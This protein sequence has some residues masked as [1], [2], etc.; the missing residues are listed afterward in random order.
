MNEIQ[1]IFSNALFRVMA[2]WFGFYIQDKVAAS[3][4][5]PLAEVDEKV[6][7]AVAEVA[8]AVEHIPNGLTPMSES[9]WAETTPV[10]NHI[11]LTFPDEQVTPSES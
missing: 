9:D 6:A 10:D 8:E 5:E 11:Y 1:K 4:L 2:T 3:I 7:E